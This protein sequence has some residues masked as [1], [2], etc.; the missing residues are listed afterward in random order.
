M[1]GDVCFLPKKA[2]KNKKGDENI[3]KNQ[4]SLRNILE[5]GIKKSD[6]LFF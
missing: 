4:L 2:Q 3:P 5:I 6:K 1:M